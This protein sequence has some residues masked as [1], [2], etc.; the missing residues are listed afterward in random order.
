MA[1]SEELCESILTYKQSCES[2][3]L[4]IR[5]FEMVETALSI[6]PTHKAAARALL[7]PMLV[8][9]LN[10][11]GD[12][13]PAGRLQSVQAIQKFSTTTLKLARK[14]WPKV[15]QDRVEKQTKAISSFILWG[16]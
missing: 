3:G 1:E 4:N 2:L 14:E 15:L 16:F 11:T 7:T 6:N 13:D 9:L 5:T 12:P 8:E 10:R